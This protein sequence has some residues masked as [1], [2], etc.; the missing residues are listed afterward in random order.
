ME[1]SDIRE[2]VNQ[3]TIELARLQHLHADMILEVT[4]IKKAC[5]RTMRWICFRQTLVHIV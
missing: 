2:Q 5:L 4:Q 1:S 3:V